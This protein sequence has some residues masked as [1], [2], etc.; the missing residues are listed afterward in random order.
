MKQLFLIELTDIGRQRTYNH[1]MNIRTANTDKSVKH[2]LELHD[3]LLPEGLKQEVRQWAL[4][5]GM[6]K[7]LRSSL[8][9]ILR[10]RPETLGYA[11][12]HAFVSKCIESGIDKDKALRWARETLN[13]CLEMGVEEFAIASNK[14]NILFRQDNI[15]IDAHQLA[16]S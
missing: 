12:S 11:I 14:G 15:P 16:L 5:V 10:C 6:N 8:Q 13:V 7:R 1:E 3:E 4:D 2:W 9:D